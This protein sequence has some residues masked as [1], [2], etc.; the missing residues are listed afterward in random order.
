MRFSWVERN[1][2]EENAVEWPTQIL[3]R[4][5]KSCFQPREEQPP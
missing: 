4:P 5:L 1:K 3:S 2:E